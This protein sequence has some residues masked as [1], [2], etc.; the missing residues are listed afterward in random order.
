MPHPT[1]S[2]TTRRTAIVGAVAGLLVLIGCEGDGSGRR[3]S[4]VPRTAAS[5][6]PD[7]ALLE[8]V[9]RELDELVA[10]VAAASRRAPGAAADLAGLAALH[11]AHRAVLPAGEPTRHRARLAGPPRAVVRQVVARERRA[12]DRLADWA[13]AAQSGALARLLASMSAAVSQ[14]LAVL[15]AGR[16]PG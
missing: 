12:R 15:G 14:E 6:D 5:A 7:S 1:G 16:V 9:G 8:V 2:A 11:R 3:S 4:P 13:V 10:L